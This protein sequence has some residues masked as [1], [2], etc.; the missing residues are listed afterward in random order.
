MGLEIEAK[1]KLDD[2]S[3]VLRILAAD[4]AAPP[5]EHLEI[6]TFLDMPDRALTKNDRGLRIRTDRDLGAGREDVI[7]TY[8]G[9]RQAGSLKTREEVELHATSD[10]DA[11]AL[12]A[13]L[14]F[15]K[16]L[17][18]EKRRTSFKFMKC[19]VEFDRLPI[20]GSFV[21]IEGPDQ[22][23]VM[24]AR[25]ALGLAD[26][27]LISDSYATMLNRHLETHGIAQRDLKLSAR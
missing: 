13:C 15:H 9:P 14:G 27:P 12:L 19:K 23:S 22:A 2:P 18:F 5:I 3:A 8:K 20:L 6:N 25:K 7:I 17:R 1:M 10:A 21:E 4:G 26:V 24:A 16:T 11:A